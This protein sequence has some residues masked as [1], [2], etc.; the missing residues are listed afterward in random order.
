MVTDPRE[1]KKK[2]RAEK[3]LKLGWF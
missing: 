1:K 3:I 2:R